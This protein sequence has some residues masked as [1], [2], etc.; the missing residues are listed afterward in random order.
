MDSNTFAED[1]QIDPEQLDVE[2]VKQADRT[3]HYAEQSVHARA[4]V[5]RIKLQMELIEARLALD[6]RE[7]PENFG[8]SKVTEAGIAAAVRLRKEY[9]EACKAHIEAREESMLLEKAVAAME[10]KESMI[11]VLVSLHGQQYF[12][13]PSVPRDLVSAWK[14][15]QEKTENSVNTKQI[16]KTRKRKKGGSE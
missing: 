5:D 4:N 3:F 9:V 12:A 1:R 14:E 13:G 7:H 2:A 11:K 8:L 15:A 10:M 16:S 6:C